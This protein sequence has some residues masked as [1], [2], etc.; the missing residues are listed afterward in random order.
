LTE[1]VP[2]LQ[3]FEA[4]RMGPT[5]ARGRRDERAGHVR[6]LT[7]SSSLIVA[8]VRGPDDPRAFRSRIAARAF[9][10]A[11]WSRVEDDLASQARFVADLL[12]GRMPAGIEAVFE[13][14]GLNLLPLSIGDIAMDCSCER[15]PMPCVHLA[16]TIYAAARSFETD[17]FGVFAWRG[18]PRDELLHRLGQLRG[19]AAVSAQIAAPVA[20]EVVEDG[21]GDPA[22]FWGR[23]GE[24]GGSVVSAAGL[25]AARPDAILDQLDAP[26]VGGDGSIAEVLRPAY[27]VLPP[28]E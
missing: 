21:L 24:V 1:I 18:R 27:L 2:F 13:A 6:S 22:D 12:A 26:V 8:Q 11:E 3:M 25:G 20:D 19:A 5:F 9:G 28:D 7:V 15:W 23:P 14:A 17:P 10:A 16:A 4:L